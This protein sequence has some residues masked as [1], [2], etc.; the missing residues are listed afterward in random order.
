MKKRN[1]RQKGKSTTLAKSGVIDELDQQ[2]EQLV[3]PATKSHTQPPTTVRAGKSTGE[4]MCR[5][6]SDN[7][8]DTQGCPSNNC[9]WPGLEGVSEGVM[10]PRKRV[11][12]S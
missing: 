2:C 3:H 1:D 11:C 12:E 9:Q 7:D 10:T 5:T 6:R 8:N 4:W